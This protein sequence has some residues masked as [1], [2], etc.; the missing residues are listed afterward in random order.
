M[1]HNFSAFTSPNVRTERVSFLFFPSSNSEASCQ[2]RNI[3]RDDV[4]N[5]PDRH[6]RPRH[7]RQ[8]DSARETLVTLR[9][10]VLEADLQLDRLEEVALLL[11]VRVVEEL[12]Y[13]LAHSGCCNALAT[14]FARFSFISGWEE[15]GV[16]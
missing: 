12:L 8:L 4:S 6:P 16:R 5:P 9:V 10:I 7:P 14:C 1:A 11:V 2:E 13:V 3:E 15:R